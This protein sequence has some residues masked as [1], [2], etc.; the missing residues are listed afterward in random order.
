MKLKLLTLLL[1]AS[2]LTAACSDD[3][4]DGTGPTGQA[5]VR[6]VH[7]SPDAPAVDVLVDDAVALSN[8]SYLATSNYL[9]LADGG[10]NVNVNAAGTSTTVIDAD[11][12]LADGTDYTLIASGLLD[13]IAP[14]VLTDDNSTPPA[15]TARVRAIHGAPSAPAVDVYV[16]APEADLETASP[17]LSSVAFGDVADYLE[18]PAGDYQVRVTPAGSKTV[19]IDSGAL[20]LASGQVRTAIAVDAA[21]GGAPFD[22]LVLQ[23]VN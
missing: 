11:V 8:V 4:D 18:V 23:D 13:A 21:G 22:L 7:A 12:D 3:D 17:V 19:V 5:R 16:T 1:A 10:H 6:V 20:T 15:G 2:A 9:E 14:I